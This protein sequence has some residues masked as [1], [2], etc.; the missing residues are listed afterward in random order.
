MAGAVYSFN[1]APLVLYASHY[2]LLVALTSQMMIVAI[3]TCLTLVVDIIV[4]AI[5]GSTRL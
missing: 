3:T 1:Q 5:L 2:C 4:Q